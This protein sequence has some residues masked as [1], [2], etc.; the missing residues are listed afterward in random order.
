MGIRVADKRTLFQFGADGKLQEI[1]VNPLND[2][3]LSS[4]DSTGK[5]KMSSKFGSL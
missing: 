5:S 2:E 4:K 1:W 3:Q